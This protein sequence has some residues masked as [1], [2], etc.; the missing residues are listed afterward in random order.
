MAT[1]LSLQFDP[2]QEYQHDAMSSVVNL[3]D[4]LPTYRAE[5]ALGGDIVPNLPPFQSLSDSWLLDNLRGVQSHNGLPE[6]M[7]LEHE[8][9]LVMEGAGDESWRYPSFTIE[10]ETG[11]GKTY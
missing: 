3:F 4:G 6:A 9:G 5:F 8:D 11:T 2:N 10:M 1:K 7:M